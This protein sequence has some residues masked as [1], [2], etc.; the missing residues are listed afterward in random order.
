MD[1]ND[2][3]DFL[4]GSRLI[5]RPDSVP[6]QLRGIVC[7]CDVTETEGWRP[8]WQVPPLTCKKCRKMPRYLVRQCRTCREVFAKDFDHTNWTGEYPLCWEHVQNPTEE[9]KAALASTKYGF[10]D[11][12]VSPPYFAEK[13]RKSLQPI[14]EMKLLGFELRMD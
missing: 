6:K 10:Q 8:A 4:V 13:L 5:H 12:R 1:L 9:A 11:H 3:K 7:T 14:D 2:E